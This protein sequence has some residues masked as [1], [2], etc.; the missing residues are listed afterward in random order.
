MCAPLLAERSRA[1]GG[2]TP[3]QLLAP[4]K[5]EAARSSRAP[6]ILAGLLPKRSIQL[7]LCMESGV[8]ARRLL[9]RRPVL[10]AAQGQRRLGFVPRQTGLGRLST[11]RAP[12]RVVLL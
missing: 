4:Y 2:N 3:Q 8:P 11:E 7:L 9:D 6:P 12:V 1:T 5:Q 10:L